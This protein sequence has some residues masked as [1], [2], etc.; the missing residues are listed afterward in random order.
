[1]S[2][3]KRLLLFNKILLSRYAPVGGQ[4]VIEGVMMRSPR[5]VATAVQNQAGEITLEVNPFSSVTKKHVLL[6]VP[7]IRGV[8][9]M[10]ETLLLGMKCLSFSASAAV[11]DEEIR[12]G[13]EPTEAKGISNWSMGLTMFLS[14]A[15]GLL[16]FFYIP[17]KLTD[18][19]GWKAGSASTWSTGSSA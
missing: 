12:E 3:K 2:I 10:V 9:G 19:M 15:L 18:W 11:R 17:L 7:V 16:V 14:F 6:R 5:M 13:K 8:V 1:M 4:A